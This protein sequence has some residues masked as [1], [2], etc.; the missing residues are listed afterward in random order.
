MIIKNPQ[1]LENTGFA[2]SV[3]SLFTIQVRLIPIMTYVVTIIKSW[4]PCKYQ[5]FKLSQMIRTQFLGF[6]SAYS[7]FA[8]FLFKPFLCQIIFSFSDSQKFYTQ[9]VLSLILRIA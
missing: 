9:N 8:K 7:I 5:C 1:S 6:Y 2:D 4:K 3:F